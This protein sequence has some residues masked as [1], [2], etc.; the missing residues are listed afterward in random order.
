MLSILFA[1]P[2]PGRLIE[3]TAGSQIMGDRL[4]R[5]SPTACQHG[6][7]PPPSLPSSSHKPKVA[8]GWKS[9]AMGHIL[10]LV[11]S[12][13]RIAGGGNGGDDEPGASRIVTADVPTWVDFAYSSDF[14]PPSSRPLPLSPSP[15]TQWHHQWD[16]KTQVAVAPQQYVYPRCVRTDWSSNL[17]PGGESA[18]GQRE[19]RHKSSPC[20]SNLMSG[21]SAP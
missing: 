2:P 8:C 14:L 21:Q 12:C 18:R 11:Y 3:R 17:I 19:A 16:G 7:G 6:G 20:H 10:A 1:N 13:H 5:C 4:H 15:H 9:Q